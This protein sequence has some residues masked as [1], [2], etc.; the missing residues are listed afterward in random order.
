VFGWLPVLGGGTVFVGLGMIAGE[1]YPV[2]RLMDRLEA[3]ARIL[4]GPPGRKLARLP[5][6]SQFSISLTVG[7]ATFTL[8]YSLYSLTFGG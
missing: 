6:W 8:V 5:G 4:F 3:R 7:L 2:G 1:F